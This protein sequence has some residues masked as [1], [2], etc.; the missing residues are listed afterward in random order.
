MLFV[1]ISTQVRSAGCHLFCCVSI[2]LDADRI[3]VHACQPMA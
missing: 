1:G 3:A 2:V